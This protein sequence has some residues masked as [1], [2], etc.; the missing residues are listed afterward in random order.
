MLVNKQI[1]CVDYLIQFIK[2]TYN[3]MLNLYGSPKV[4]AVINCLKNVKSGHNYFCSQ[5]TAEKIPLKK[6]KKIAV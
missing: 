3:L 5:L 2:T 4:W 6:L 1:Y